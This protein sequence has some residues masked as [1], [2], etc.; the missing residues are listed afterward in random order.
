MLTGTCSAFRV[1]QPVLV[2]CRRGKGGGLLLTCAAHVTP[3]VDLQATE[4]N[5]VEAMGGLEVAPPK[6]VPA[7][8]RG[9]PA[10]A[11]RLH[12]WLSPGGHIPA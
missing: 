8:L 7:P 3:L 4:A 1:S 10:P 6:V 2:A 5:L 9:L 12:A 11:V